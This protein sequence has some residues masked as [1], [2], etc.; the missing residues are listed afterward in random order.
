[1]ADYV[2]A[3]AL[4]ADVRLRLDGLGDDAAVLVVEGADDK[5]VFYRHMAPLADVM[6]C[7]GKRLLRASLAAMLATDE[8]RILFVTDCDYD[9]LN[10]TLHGGP[11]MVITKA[12]DVEAD[13]IDLGVLEKLIPEVVPNAMGSKTSASKIATNARGYAEKVAEIMGR[14]RIVAQP[15][16]VDLDFDNWDLLKFWDAKSGEPLA[17]K[18]HQAVLARLKRASVSISEADWMAR[19]G[20]VSDDCAVCNGKDLI[21]AVQMVLHTRYKMNH[22]FSKEIIAGMMRLALDD[23]QFANWSVVTRIRAWEKRHGRALLL[24]A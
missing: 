10:G 2:S 16:G 6:P 24:A 20:D 13:L 9:V 4:L 19:I 11:N 3:D 1:V 22:K 23:A 14:I 12:C 21:A 7:G 18:M 15:I 8:G 5:R 17:K